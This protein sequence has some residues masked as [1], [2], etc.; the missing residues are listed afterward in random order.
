MIYQLQRYSIK[1]VFVPGKDIPV[2]DTLSRKFLRD[3]D[4]DISRDL[5]AQVHLVTSNIEISDRTIQVIRG[6]TNTDPQCQ[7]LVYLRQ[8]PAVLES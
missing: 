8:R 7:A 4:P 6:S 1:L 3:Q 2:A 5:D